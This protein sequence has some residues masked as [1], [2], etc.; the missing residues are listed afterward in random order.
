MRLKDIMTT[1]V[2]TVAYD[3][4]AVLANEIM[5]RKQIHHLVVVRG[6]DIV[7][8]VSDT[9]LGG[10]EADTIPDNLQVKDVMTTSTVTATPD[11]TIKRAANL[12]RGHNIHSLPILEHG[13]LV[14]IVT[15]TDLS[16]LEKRG[17]SQPPFEGIQDIGPYVPLEHR[18]RHRKRTYQHTEWPRE[19][20]EHKKV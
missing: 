15:A 18:G 17:R 14:G 13:K 4:P 16:M 20:Y 3:A 10:P 6:K 7:G 11:T 8:V 9:D 19:R 12:M 5:W 2:E 1:D